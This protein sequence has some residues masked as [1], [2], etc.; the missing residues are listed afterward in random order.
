MDRLR[1][2]IRE[3]R[4]LLI[5]GSVL[6]LIPV[7]LRLLLPTLIE[8]GTAYGSRHYLGLP[9][10]IDSVELS[11]LKGQIVLEGLSVASVPDQVTP[12]KAALNPPVIDPSTALMHCK[13][14]SVRLSWSSLLKKT[15]H[16]TEVDIDTPSI[17]LLREKGGR[18][19]PLSHAKPLTP[20]AKKETVQAP[21]KPSSKPWGIVID[22]FALRSPNLVIIDPALGKNLLEFSLRQFTLD[23]LSVRGSDLSLGAVGVQGTE[24]RVQKDLM[25]SGSSAG[26]T[27]P[28]PSSGTTPSQNP[29]ASSDAPALGY[30][31]KTIDIA[32]T[33]FT[34]ITKEGPLD[35]TLT[36]KASNVTADQGKHF[37][38]SLALQIAN[39]TIGVDGDVGILP[40]SYSGK[41]TWSNLPFPPLLLH[42]LP[43]LAVWLRSADSDGDLRIETD[44]SGVHGPP[45][46]R[47]SGRSTIESLS[48]ADPGNKELSIS[49]KELELVMNDAV[50][51][52]PD[53]SKSLPPTKVNFEL[54]RL[55]EPKVNYTH[56]ASSLNALLGVSPTSSAT[57]TTTTTTTNAPT[58]PTPTSAASSQ[59]EARIA[60]LELI[61]GNI[62]VNDTTVKPTAVSSI[63]GLSL[64]LHGVSYPDPSADTISIQAILPTN[65]TLAIDGNLK[66]GNVGSYTLSLKSLDLPP[67]SPYAAAAGATL[68]AGQISVTTKLATQ[69]ALMQIDND[70]VLQRFGISLRDPNSFTRMFGMPIDL[71]IALLSDPSGDIKLTVPLR[72]DEKG[73]T[74]STGAVMASALKTAILGAVS[75]PLKLLGGSFGGTSGTGPASFTIAPIKSPAGS[76]ELDSSASGRID[77]LVKLLAQRPEIGL[78]LR[79]RT[80]TDDRPPVA[81][82]LLVER[83]GQGKG[84][85]ELDGAGFLAR[86]RIKQVLSRRSK[87]KPAS[88]SA[89]DQPLFN[90]YL[91]AV[92]IPEDRLDALAKLRAEKLREM[93]VAKGVHA[94]RL[95]VGSR[96]AVGEAGVVISFQPK[97]GVSAPST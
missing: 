86:L 97:Q 21:A 1:V 3:R 77:G 38:I 65:S 75:T 58:P 52:I 10:R 33:K 68:D 71:M 29:K 5:L 32:H 93:L 76:P 11:L 59:L 49:W 40:P 67:F 26:A 91:A 22:Q 28:K 20:P 36:L 72:I 85:P 18:I 64:S 27:P 81:E 8:R 94:G 47:L 30:R 44:L 9:A 39:G 69:G 14:I 73:S 74:V 54:I 57:T 50:I 48:I 34:W 4:R 19:D 56:P 82:Q 6:I 51:P 12:I 35:V 70:L 42:S 43:E 46:I 41:F 24:L 45:S 88:V 13:R 87:G 80:G 84:L 90:R 25:A 92:E 62:E 63:S 66:S 83:V 96:E 16:F 15:V 79:G 17:H 95:S 31:I 7:G 2:F 53:G 55:V 61:G 23:D 60:L 89:E 78:M 37:P